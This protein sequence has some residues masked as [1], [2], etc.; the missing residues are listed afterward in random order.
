MR[1]R[2]ILRS[3]LGDAL[4]FHRLAGREALSQS[5]VFDVD[6]LG[7]SNAIDAKALLGKPVT[8]VM[9]TESGAPRY[10]SGLVTRFGLAQQDDRQAFYKMRLRPW[11]WLATRRSDFRI[12]QDQTVP[13]IL[14]EV[15]GRYG[16]PI[17]HKLTRSDYRR[18][19]YCV[20]Y[21]ES[22]FDFISRLCEH[23][24]VCYHFRHEAEQHVLVFADDI[25]NSHSPLPGGEEVRYHPL[26]K[27]GMGR[28][29]R[30]YAWEIAEEVRSGHH[31][32]DDHDFEK[33]QAEL[34][35]LRQMP[36]GHDH[37]AFERYE[38]PG[39]FTQHDDGETYAR[40]RTEE[41]LSERSRASGRANRRDLAPGCTFTLTHH[42]REDQNR[43]H[44]LVS[45]AY[46]LQENLQASEGAEGAEGSVQRFAFEAQPTSYAWRPRRSTP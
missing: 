42:P 22:D 16:H 10:L 3:P 39:G 37:G 26:E 19:T 6:L 45:V 36:P 28:R 4:Q 23:E 21:H 35:H 5:Y 46:E 34:S 25:A 33:P 2:V 15:L 32:T 27:S 8:V 14:G 29:E 1:R 20:Q 12:F 11:L 7:R 41:Q 31:Y 38:W 40:L 44:L 17:E 30:I 9:E 13:E 24:G 43:E 18:W